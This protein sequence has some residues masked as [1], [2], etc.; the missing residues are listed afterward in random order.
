[1]CTVPKRRKLPIQGPF[2][3]ITCMPPDVKFVPMQNYAACAY[4]SWTSQSTLQ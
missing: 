1:M 4:P 2:L 3:G